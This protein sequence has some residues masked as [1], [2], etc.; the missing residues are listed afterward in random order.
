MQAKV[1]EPHMKGRNKIHQAKILNL[2]TANC[3]IFILLIHLTLI[4]F[5][6]NLILINFIIIFL[7]FKF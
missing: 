6:T 1:S 2:T 4:H 7:N 5:S 3:R